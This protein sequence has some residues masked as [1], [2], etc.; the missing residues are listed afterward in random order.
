MHGLV[1]ILTTDESEKDL[2]EQNNNSVYA[3]VTIKKFFEF[4]FN[5]V[6]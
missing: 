6:L 4:L 3:M 2:N 5:Q 1:S